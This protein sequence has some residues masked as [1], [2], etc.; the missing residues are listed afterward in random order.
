MLDS[1]NSITTYVVA[2]IFSF[3]L[4]I[5]DGNYFYGC[6]TNNPPASYVFFNIKI[7]GGEVNS[8]KIT[9]VLL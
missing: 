2:G 6:G 3:G 5:A 4:D 7:G 1:F 9:F 8:F